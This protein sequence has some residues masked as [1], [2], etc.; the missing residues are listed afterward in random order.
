M[1]VPRVTGDTRAP[2]HSLRGLGR[3]RA[4]CG[5]AVEYHSQGSVGQVGDLE[6]GPDGG[7]I[8]GGRA[9]GNEHQVGELRR[10]EGAGGRMGRG[11]DDGKVGH[12]GH[13][14]GLLEL[15]VYTNGGPANLYRQLSGQLSRIHAPAS[16]KERLP[17]SRQ[18]K[19]MPARPARADGASGG[20][21]CRGGRC[22]RSALTAAPTAS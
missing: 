10:G 20:C 4:A 19:G 11:V 8:G 15:R 9:T 6:A 13:A 21:G 17:F 12:H 2:V 5:Y 14:A 18:A 1:R 22:P 7:Q 3:Q 16:S